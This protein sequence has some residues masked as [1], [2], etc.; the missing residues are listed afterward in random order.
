MYYNTTNEKGVEL[1]ESTKKGQNTG[2]ANT[3][4]VPGL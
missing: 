2:S 4:N 3:S 1:A